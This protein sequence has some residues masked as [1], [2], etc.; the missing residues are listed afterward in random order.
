MLV[1]QHAIWHFLR[2]LVIS[3]LGITLRKKRSHGHGSSWQRFSAWSRTVSTHLSMERMTRHLKS[4]T[5]RSV[6]LQKRS[7]VF[8]VTRR[9]EN[10]ITSGSMVQDL[11]DRVL[12]SIMIVEKNTAVANR[13]VRS[14][15]NVTVSWK[16]G[17]TYLH[18]STAMARVATVS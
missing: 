17:T 6:Y 8:I 2:C 12:K 10:V 4:G 1:R 3:L 11:A 5:K 15:V 9:P 16:Y 14:A 13:I 18:S 7:L